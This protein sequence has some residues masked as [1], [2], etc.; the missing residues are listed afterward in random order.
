MLKIGDIVGDLKVI[1]VI[2]STKEIPYIRYEVECLICHRKKFI[3][4]NTLQSKSLSHKYCKTKLNK[5]D[6]IDLKFYHIWKNAKPDMYFVDFYDTFYSFYKESLQLNPIKF[7]FEQFN[8][9]LYLIPIVKNDKTVTYDGHIYLN[10]PYFNN[11]C[12]IWEGIRT[13]TNNPNNEYFNH[14][15]GRKIS[16]DGYK[17]FIDFYKKLYNDYKK[18]IK[19][20]PNEKITIDRIDVNKNYCKEN[21][22]WIPISWQ[23]GNRKQNKW[24]KIISA[25]NKVYL[26]KNLFNFSTYMNI[27]YNTAHDN[28]I[29]Q[30]NNT[31]G[32][33]FEYINIKNYKNLPINEIDIIIDITNYPNYK[34]VY[35]KE[36]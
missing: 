16:S 3:R 6:K 7:I 15:G 12:S 33:K 36:A 24:I 8:E 30:T 28:L 27:N 1:K 26:T 21:I 20:Y 11:F 23:N 35:K 14:Y 10:E 9:Q 32:W 18:A 34:I 25:E 2:H 4:Q 5:K 13:R 29:Y 17:H 19:Q 31:Q 22:R